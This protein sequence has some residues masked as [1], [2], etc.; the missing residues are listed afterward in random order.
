MSKSKIKSKKINT[1]I[2]KTEIETGKKYFRFQFSV[3]TAMSDS[4]VIRPSFSI[5]RRR[6]Y[7]TSNV[8]IRLHQIRSKS[9]HH[10]SIPRNKIFLESVEFENTA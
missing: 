3:I 2:I 8:F 1:G 5:S 4:I 6:L 10:L 9:I 7:P